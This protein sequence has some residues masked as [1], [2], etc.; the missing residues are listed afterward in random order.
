MQQSVVEGVGLLTEVSA[1][2]SQQLN[3]ATS[4]HGSTIAE[5]VKQYTTFY[6]AYALIIGYSHEK[7]PG[8]DQVLEQLD[9]AKTCIQAFNKDSNLSEPLRRLD[10]IMSRLRG[11]KST[12]ASAP[13]KSKAKTSDK[14]KRGRYEEVLEAV[15]ERF[16]EGSDGVAVAIGAADTA[17]VYKI[18]GEFQAYYSRIYTVYQLLIG[19]LESLAGA[20]SEKLA[21]F[22]SRVLPTSL[23]GLIGDSNNDKGRTNS[24]SVQELLAMPAVEYLKWLL[25]RISMDHYVHD[26]SVGLLSLLQSSGIDTEVRSDITHSLVR[27]VAAA[28]SFQRKQNE[29]ARTLAEGI[30][31][32]MD[33]IRGVNLAAVVGKMETMVEELRQQSGRIRQYRATQD[34]IMKIYTPDLPVDYK[35]SGTV[36]A[37]PIIVEASVFTDPLRIAELRKALSQYI[38]RLDIAYKILVPV[39][40]Y[41]VTMLTS[42]AEINRHLRAIISD[43]VVRVQRMNLVEAYVRLSLAKELVRTR[44][45]E[46]GPEETQKLQGTT[47][48]LLARLESLFPGVP[49]LYGEELQLDAVAAILDKY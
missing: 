17:P 4:A 32:E 10:G 47:E 45:G 37:K 48:T 3:E 26:Q 22:Y 46:L 11:E 9:V 20:S 2:L 6:T 30:F 7:S 24:R 5:L 34:G 23:G 19:D 25:Q 42:M 43:D 21:D 27:A 12:S 44:T 28:V 38:E 33:D 14:P 16:P 40:Q 41:Y 8:K 18:G 15:Q 39:E 29:S 1:K 49:K 36:L 31:N 13:T 35:V